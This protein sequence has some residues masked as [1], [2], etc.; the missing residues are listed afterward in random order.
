MKKAGKAIPWSCARAQKED[1]WGKKRIKL[2]LLFFFFSFSF[3]N[4]N[5]FILIGG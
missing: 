3:F 4:I 2:I 1:V 5:L